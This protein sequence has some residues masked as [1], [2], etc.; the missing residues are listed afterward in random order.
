M[1]LISNRPESMMD[2]IK[3]IH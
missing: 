3:H 2:L 1:V